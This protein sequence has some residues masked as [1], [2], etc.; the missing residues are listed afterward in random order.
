MVAAGLSNPTPRVRRASQGYLGLTDIYRY[1]LRNGALAGGYTRYCDT[2]ATRI[3]RQT[4]W[5]QTP[6]AL[7]V[8]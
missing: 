5:H 7:A 3:D 6:L 2:I 4:L 1:R 8:D